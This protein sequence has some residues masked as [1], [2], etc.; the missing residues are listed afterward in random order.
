[1]II[2]WGLFYKLTSE[3]LEPCTSITKLICSSY[4]LIETFNHSHTVGDLRHL[5][6]RYPFSHCLNLH[7]VIR[8][9]YIVLSLRAVI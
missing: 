5:I 9:V 6:S 3:A 1:M 2:T 7:V 8:L 4:S